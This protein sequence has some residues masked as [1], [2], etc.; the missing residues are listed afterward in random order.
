MPGGDV[1]QDGRLAAAWRVAADHI[2]RD[3]VVYA[4]IALHC[5]ACVAILSTR[6]FGKAFAFEGYLFVWSVAFLLFF[7]ALLLLGL[8][9]AIVHRVER[10]R[11]LA[12]RMVLSPRRVGRAAAGAVLL[13]ALMAFEGSFTSLKNAAPLFRGGFPYDRPQA[14]LDR[15]LHFGRD[16]WTLLHGWDGGGYLLAFVQ[17]NYVQGWFFLCF[18]MLFL[19]CVLPEF[20]RIRSRYMLCYIAAWTIVG[21]VL[22]TAFLSAGPAFY[23]EVTGDAARFSGLGEALAASASAFSA[24]SIQAS[25]WH[26]HAMG[27]SG[28][29]SGISAFP[30]MHVTLVTLNALFL[31]EWKPR[32]GML[33]FAYAGL[34][35]LSSVYLGWHY[36]IDGYAGLAAAILIHA[37]ARRIFRRGP[38]GLAA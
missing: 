12:F 3:R 6:G 22:A 8:T 34:I 28:F 16:P 15:W 25:L 5:L 27:E 36:A 7:P 33:G 38:G 18:G 13:L 10:R 17:W 32:L 11:R 29:G 2:R 30:S 37:L 1:R 26:L 4:L 14:D 21:N 9:L 23:G 35:F 31:Y 20:D 24:A 19:I